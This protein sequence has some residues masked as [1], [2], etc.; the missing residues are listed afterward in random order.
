MT[1]RSS[2]PRQLLTSSLREAVFP[3]FPAQKEGCQPWGK[4]AP[5]FPEHFHSNDLLLN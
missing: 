4:W 1:S 2:L 3:P 5:T